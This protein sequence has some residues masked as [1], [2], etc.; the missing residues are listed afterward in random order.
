MKKGKLMMPVKTTEKKDPFFSVI[1]TSYKDE[2]YVEEC[3][4]SIL[5]QGLDVKDFEIIFT[6]D[7]SNDGTVDRIREFMLAYPEID[8]K[9]IV[10]EKNIG[11]GPSRNKAISASR[12]KYIAFVDADDYLS[13]NGLKKGKEIIQ[14]T[15]A[16]LLITK[17]SRFKD[18]PDVDYDVKPLPDLDEDKI[19]SLHGDEFFYVLEKSKIELLSSSVNIL[20]RDLIKNGGQFDNTPHEDILWTLDLQM[21]SKN[22][23]LCWQ[24]YYNYRKRAGTITSSNFS[25][26][27]K[28]LRDIGETVKRKKFFYPYRRELLDNRANTILNYADRVE[29]DAQKRPFHRNQTQK[30]QIE[31]SVTSGLY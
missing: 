16:D 21:K 14:F 4:K 9:L 31:T 2:K 5:D 22:P 13:R 3:A 10:N 8:A 11:L 15:G 17:L 1:V 30:S 20:V 27:A 7:A 23:Q 26:R 24:D 29:A 19:N 25:G 6:N 28:T 18:N 12:G